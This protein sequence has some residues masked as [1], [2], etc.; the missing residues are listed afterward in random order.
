MKTLHML[1][2]ILSAFILLFL[3]ACTSQPSTKFSNAQ[4]IKLEGVDQSHEFPG[5]NAIATIGL[6]GTQEEDINTEQ[7]AV[8]FSASEASG[9][10]ALDGGLNAIH[11]LKG[12]YDLLDARFTNNTTYL[13]TTD[14]ETGLAQLI[15]YRSKGFVPIKTLETH[16]FQ[17]EGMCL[18][19]NAYGELFAFLLDGYGVGELRWLLTSTGD[20]VDKKVKTLRLPPESESCS[21]DDESES[22]FVVEEGFGLWRY[23]ANPESSRSRVLVDLVAPRGKIQGAPKSVRAINETILVLT[24]SSLSR[25]QKAKGEW[26]PVQ[27]HDLQNTA[28]GEIGD[29]SIIDN[30]FVFV[31]EDQGKV[32]VVESGARVAQAEKPS[33]TDDI[34]QVSAKAQTEPMDRIGDAADDPAIWVNAR[35][36]ERSR[37]L[38]TNKKWGLFVYDLNGRTVQSIPSG[39]INNVD[40]R[41]NVQLQSGK[42]DI[43][44]ASNRSDNSITV[45]SLNLKTGDVSE[46]GRVPTELEEVYGICLYAPNQSALHAFINDKDGRIQQWQLDVDRNYAVSGQL[47]RELKLNSQPEGCV[48]NDETHQLFVGE[49]DLGVWL[50][51]ARVES[52]SN[53]SDQGT[54]IHEVGGRLI[55]DVEGLALVQY[56]G[57]SYL[58]VSSQGNHTYVLYDAAAPYSHRGTFRVGLNG[59]DGI[60]GTSE[61]DGL[62]VIAVNLGPS[63]P[64]GIV[65]IQDGFNYMPE[66]PQNF[67][68][69]SWKDVV[70]ALGIAQ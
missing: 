27:A 63:Y 70:D 3:V 10:I 58:L 18:Y 56:Q 67:K 22:F 41:Q 26:S 36:P 21:V 65:V 14:A 61:T 2:N 51:D 33:K 50:F 20:I 43:A 13:I 32:H 5:V 1:L 69:V 23:S 68:Y 62:D 39:H 9:L 42:F 45:Y 16:H 57:K 53:N 38:G 49:E 24:E 55:A 19:L 44:V 30:R 60:D 47:L 66:Q 59:K 12:K 48:A 37:I 54:L 11:T 31:G 29:I 40:I 64:E 6:G 8:L 4:R 34:P 52:P 17:I 15:E 28:M 46:I 35:S 25:Y 7:S